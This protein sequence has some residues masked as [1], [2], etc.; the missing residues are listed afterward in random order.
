MSS[1]PNPLALSDG[2]LKL[3]MRAAS[4]LLP[5]ARTKFLE[6]VADELLAVEITDAVIAAAIATVL[7]RLDLNNDAA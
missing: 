3:V 1:K 5:T 2:Q 7:A 6:A 4:G